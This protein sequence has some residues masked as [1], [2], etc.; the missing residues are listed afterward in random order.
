[1]DVSEPALEPDPPPMRDGEMTV[2]LVERVPGDEVKGWV[3]YYRFELWT[4]GHPDPVGH[5]NLRVGDTEHVVMYAG[6]VGYSV[7]RAFRGRRYAARA[8]RMVLDFA[9]DI[10]IDAV[11]ITCNPDNAPSVRT[12]EILG[13]ERVDEVDVPPRTDMYE[14]GETRKVRFLV[15]TAA[16]DPA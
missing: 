14:R 5:V 16:R 12:I 3:P 15:R 13:G 7:S 6:H 2:V 11:W 4:D 8:T 1:M 9:N 10:G